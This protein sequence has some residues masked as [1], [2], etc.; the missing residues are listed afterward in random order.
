MPA[1]LPHANTKINTQTC[2]LAHC[3]PDRPGIVNKYWGLQVSIHQPKNIGIGEAT[4]CTCVECFFLVK[5]D[6]ENVLYLF[7][8]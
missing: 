2:T 3:L 4:I 1:L 6:D 7:V 5:S 8:L